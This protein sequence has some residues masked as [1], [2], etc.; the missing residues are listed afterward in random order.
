[1]R[2]HPFPLSRLTLSLLLATGLAPEWAA[3]V[4]AKSPEG[5]S[6]ASQALLSQA[7]PA[8]AV[9]EPVSASPSDARPADAA[10]EDTGEAVEEPVTAAAPASGSPQLQAVTVTGSAV[11]RVDAE[12]AVP[13]TILRTE[14]LQQEGVTSTE[15]L[16]NRITGAQNG[17]NSSQSVGAA[18][19]GASFADMRGIGAN[20]T[21][22]L[23]NGRRL[24][25]NALDGS[26]VDLNTI[27]F[28]AIERVEVLRD[29]A[30][31]LYGTDAIGGVINFI[32]KDS[33]QGGQISLGGETPLS[34][35][36]GDK[37]P[38]F[39]ASYGF[40]N[41]QEDRFNLFGS[42]SY[43]KQ[44]NLAL[45]DRSFAKEYVPGRGLDRSS[46]TAF[47]GNY[48]QGGNSANPLGPNC[49]GSRLIPGVAGT[50]RQLTSGWVDAIP[51][52]EKWSFFGKGQAKL[53]DD[54][55]VS[56][57]YFL[58]TNKNKTSIAP[59]PLTDLTMGPDNPFY[60]GNGVTPLPNGFDLDSTQDIGYGFR[61][62]DAGAR[63]SED[64]NKSQ[65]L[66]LT[67]DGTV[68]GWDYDIGASYNVNKVVNGLAGGYIDDRVVDRGI[69]QGVLNP[70]G[71]QTQAGRDLLASGDLR[72]HYETGVGRVKALD[73]KIS[74]ELGDWFGAGPAALALGGEYRKES[75]STDI[76]E[77]A[78]YLASLGV[79]PAGSVSADRWVAGEYAELNVPLLDPLEVTA[80]LRHDKYSD[81]GSTTNPK[82]SFRYQPF[83][84]LV[85]RG[86]YSTGFR[87]PSLY[88]MNTPNAI[89]WTAGN[90]N[91]PTLCPG[92]KLASGG[93]AG[94]DCGQQFH[95]RTGGNKD[96]EPEE[97][98]NVTLGFVYQPVKDLSLSV[99]FWWIKISKM[100]NE[101]PETEIFDHP[102]LY[103][104][105]LARRADGSI[106]YVDTPYDNLGKT[107]TNGVDLAL[108][109]SFP[110]TRFGHF[111]LDMT[112][113]Y[114]DR[115]DYQQEKGGAY[116]DR[117]G[118]YS[119]DQ[120]V[121]RWKHL[122]TGSWNKGPWR[123][124]LTN[125]YQT[126]YQDQDTS[127]HSRVA[128]WSLW[129]L[130]AGY[131]WR[132]NLDID[133]GLRNAFDKEPPFTNQNYNFQSGYDPRYFDSL[134]RT[135]FARTTY[136]F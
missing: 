60:P 52:T 26:A 130:S 34:S 136:R 51:E 31:S 86:A 57:E 127:T 55:K 133:V 89:D 20:K 135:L 35:G 112:G 116:H 109:Y 2:I 48:T 7:E 24:G 25:N 129:D 61:E 128:S 88:E 106:D 1:M 40:G 33:A 50:C 56:L 110:E 63:K 124:A 84:E 32:T 75:F 5:A 54:H 64:K 83:R 92:G 71:A 95:N 49:A 131:T 67:F 102:D 9:D 8:E 80:S 18:T 53:G 46:G 114:V 30:S 77:K 17:Y 104:D 19:G 12:T 74:R 101:F 10:P 45:S 122:V 44:N 90:Y 69:A 119:G 94:R 27:P 100:I 78:G 85:V 105:R 73:G 6:F 13:V 23:L 41:L 37:A 76:E 70:F 87:A 4:D 121:F 115:Y 93:V 42:L 99:D 96:L 66:L 38:D 62:I 11:R 59:S 120:V 72:G 113:T 111:G 65:R 118:T 107:K 68:Q 91:D 79:D 97:A 103:G 43:Q 22:V 39:N 15:Q 82:Y 29:G 134:G 126:G 117:V 132:K 47:P 21:L 125:R 108:S 98:R 28:S 14:K 3:A 123:A 16:V 81:A 36:G 58:A